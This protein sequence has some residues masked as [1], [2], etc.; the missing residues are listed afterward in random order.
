MLG[1]NIYIVLLMLIRN[2]IKLKN[3]K[4]PHKNYR[5]TFFKKNPV[6]VKYNQENLYKKVIIQV[7]NKLIHMWGKFYKARSKN[8]V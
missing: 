3:F 5:S 8:K 6:Q 1:K 7:T 2:K 4:N